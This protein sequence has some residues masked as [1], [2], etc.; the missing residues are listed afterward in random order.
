MRCHILQKR[1]LGTEGLSNVPEDTE[2]VSDRARKELQQSDSKI[3][4]PDTIYSGL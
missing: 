1:N 3:L 4:E 2:L